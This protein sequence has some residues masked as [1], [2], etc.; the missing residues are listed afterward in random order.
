ME[1]I[2]IIE[3][4]KA[5]LAEV[6]EM[7]AIAKECYLARWTV[8]DYQKEIARETSLI[9]T[10]KYKTDKYPT[11]VAGF[12]TS[13]FAAPKELSD[14]T[15]IYTELDVL[16]FGVLKK[17][18]QQGIGNALLEGLIERAARMRIESIWLEVRESNLAAINLYKK[19]EFSAV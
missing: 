18:R 14:K 1:D 12:I 5:T 13:R 9:L 2:F 10:A 7:V 8:D 15:K 6:S 19:K 4:S 3:V 17:Y 16:N 11:Q